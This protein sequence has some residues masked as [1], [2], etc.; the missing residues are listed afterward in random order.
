VARDKGD[1]S[2]KRRW[3]RGGKPEEGPSEEEL[4]WLADL[5]GGGREERAPFGDEPTGGMARPGRRG[6]DV[7]P[8]PVSPAPA[9]PASPPP[10]RDFGAHRP[11]RLHRHPRSHRLPRL[12]PDRPGLGR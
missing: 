11:P 3:G 6:R 5:R 7:P 10:S 9:G 2:S 4:G 12:P 8:P 1:E